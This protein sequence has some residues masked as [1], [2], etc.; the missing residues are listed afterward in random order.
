VIAQDTRSTSG[1]AAPVGELVV[2]GLALVTGVALL[3]GGLALL[4]VLVIGLLLTAVS[5]SLDGFV[6]GVPGLGLLPATIPSVGASRTTLGEI[7]TA[8]GGCPD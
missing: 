4:V 8:G 3:V 7:P 5:N 2:V 1:A 6:G